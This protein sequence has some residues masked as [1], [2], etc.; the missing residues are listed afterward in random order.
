MDSEKNCVVCNE[1][2]SSEKV[3][4]ITAARRETFKEA[5]KGRG[6]RLFTRVSE[7]D[8]MHEKCYKSYTHPDNVAAVVR[9]RNMQGPSICTRSIGAT[10]F[11]FE[12]LCIF[13]RE[14]AS[15]SFL[16]EEMKKTK[17]KRIH[18]CR[19]ENK[20]T[21]KTISERAKQRTDFNAI[22]IS[23]LVATIDLDKVTPKYHHPL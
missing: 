12:N 8:S 14:D 23:T 22:N 9:Q 2:L 4:A 10:D 19:L 6:D 18:V 17:R 1:N 5:S 13:C 3:I 15:Q 11:D 16:K 21:L 7:N 20:K